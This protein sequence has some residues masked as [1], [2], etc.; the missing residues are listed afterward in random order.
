[1]ATTTISL[2]NQ[3]EDNTKLT[4]TIGPVASN[5]SAIINLKE[6]IQTF[7]DSAQR[8]TIDEGRYAN[9]PSIF[10]SDTGSKWQKI[11]AATITTTDREYII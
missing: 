2:T 1:M 11:S 5:A 9:F 4:V 8:A 10:T 3:F 6:N 7:N